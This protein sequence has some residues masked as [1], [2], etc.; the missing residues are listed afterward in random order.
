MPLTNPSSQRPRKA[1][2]GQPFF[3]AA[4]LVGYSFS[5]A[6]SHRA[7]GLPSAEDP[8]RVAMSAASPYLFAIVDPHIAQ[9]SILLESS[10]AVMAEAPSPLQFQLFLL[11]ASRTIQNRPTTCFFKTERSGTQPAWPA[12]RA[13][14]K[15]K[16]QC[17]R[18][19]PPGSPASPASNWRCGRHLPACG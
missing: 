16:V 7:T 12:R 2:R 11:P 9:T 10:R 6:L 17:G 3:R 1:P 19:D 14:R 5:I 15:S 4:G 18:N 8:C 13:H